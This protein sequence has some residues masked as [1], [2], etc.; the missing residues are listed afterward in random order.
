MLCNCLA[1]ELPVDSDVELLIDRDLDE[2]NSPQREPFGD[3]N[4]IIIVL[5]DDSARS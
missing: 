3:E 4:D 1:Q 2:E 5:D